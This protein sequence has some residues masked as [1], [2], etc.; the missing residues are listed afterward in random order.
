MSII[1]IPKLDTDENPPKKENYRPIS[2][3]NIEV[4]ILNKIST[5]QIKKNTFKKSFTII[6]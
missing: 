6:K 2:L 5:N 4:K 3:M 1:L